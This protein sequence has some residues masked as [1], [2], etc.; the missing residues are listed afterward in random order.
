MGEIKKKKKTHR[1]RNGIKYWEDIEEN[2]GKREGQI[3]RVGKTKIKKDKYRGKYE[4]ICQRGGGAKTKGSKE[5][6]WE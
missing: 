3:R 5:G 1:G 6:K 4:R 2:E